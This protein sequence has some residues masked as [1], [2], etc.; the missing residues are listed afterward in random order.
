[1]RA[2]CRRPRQMLRLEGA[3]LAMNRL[4]NTHHPS[5]TMQFILSSLTDDM[6]GLADGFCQHL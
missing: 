5:T 6:P 2:G 4:K 3:N 1:M